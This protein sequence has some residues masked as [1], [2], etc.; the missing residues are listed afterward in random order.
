[1]KDEKQM[2]AEPMITLMKN[3]ENGERIKFLHYPKKLWKYGVSSSHSRP[4][5]YTPPAP[6]GGGIQL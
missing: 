3:M 6:Y 1:M 5:M 2:T 4:T